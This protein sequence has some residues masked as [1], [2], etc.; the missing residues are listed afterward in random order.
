MCINTSS[1]SSPLF[2]LLFSPIHRHV[3]SVRCR[4]AHPPNAPSL[5]WPYLSACSGTCQAQQPRAGANAISCLS[6]GQ[7][8]HSRP[9]YNSASADHVQRDPVAPIGG[10]DR[11]SVVHSLT[12]S[13]SPL[14]SWSKSPHLCSA[15]VP[16]LSGFPSPL[17]SHNCRKR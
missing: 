1:L 17:S 16:D 12:Q 14:A 7:Q 8:R 4:C 2:G 3:S 9:Q 10:T 11:W 13:G 15:W 6:G 5:T